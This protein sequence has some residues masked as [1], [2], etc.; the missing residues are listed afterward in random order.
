MR[1]KEEGREGKEEIIA[2]SQV[3]KRKI[4]EIHRGEGEREGERIAEVIPLLMEFKEKYSALFRKRF[5]FAGSAGK[6]KGTS[7]EDMKI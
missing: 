6:G 1:W 7:H 2:L 5:N 4:V 3:V